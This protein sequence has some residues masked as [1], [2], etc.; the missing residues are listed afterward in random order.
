MAAGVFFPVFPFRQ[1]GGHASTVLAAV[2]V[3]VVLVAAPFLAEATSRDKAVVSRHLA[4]AEDAA[5]EEHESRGIFYGKRGPRGREG[6]AGPS[7]ILCVLT[8]QTGNVISTRVGVCV[9]A[10]N[11]EQAEHVCKRYCGGLKTVGDGTYAF[12]ELR[13]LIQSTGECGE[14][15][16]NMMD[17]RCCECKVQGATK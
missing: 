9:S 3:A 7:N 17:K 2:V 8:E 14:D 13:T 11:I 6:P 10:D 4:E 12:G 16:N 1:G 5:G 15:V